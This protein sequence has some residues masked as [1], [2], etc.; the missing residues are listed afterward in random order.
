MRSIFASWLILSFVAVAV[1][2]FAAMNHGNG[3]DHGC[4]AAAAQRIDCPYGVNTLNFISFHLDALKSFST[5][6][7]LVTLILLAIGLWIAPGGFRALTG[8]NPNS[9][10]RHP[11][12]LFSPPLKT[13]LLR[14][15][16]L[17]ENSPAAL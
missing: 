16:A 15:L 12:E 3:Q 10:P 8:P 7:T 11:Y 13:E 9:R 2:G 17:H 14:W 6:L 4:L 1:F 5:G